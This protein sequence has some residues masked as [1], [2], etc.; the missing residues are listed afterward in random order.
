MFTWRRWHPEAVKVCFANPVA[1]SKDAYRRSTWSLENKEQVRRWVEDEF[2]PSRT[3][4]HFV[5]F[6]NC[7]RGDNSKV[8]INYRPK[9]ALKWLGGTLA[10]ASIGYQLVYVS[11]DFP[12]TAGVMHFFAGGLNRSTVVHEFG[13]IAGLY[14]EHD[15]PHS[16]CTIGGKE[17]EDMKWGFGYT[18]YDADSIMSYCV[19]RKWDDRGLSAGDLFTLKLMY[20]DK[21][22]S[23]TS[24]GILR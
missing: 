20:I 4:I 2:T 3:G 6:E 8:I 10:S 16:T 17:K 5:G 14:H 21:I 22:D 7:V 13:H 23:M 12:E 15:H 19:T 18:E 24:T 11:K 9:N 1:N